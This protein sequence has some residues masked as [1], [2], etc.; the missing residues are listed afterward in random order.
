MGVNE[1]GVAGTNSL[2]GPRART[3]A[4]LL[5]PEQPALSPRALKGGFS[6]DSRT[7]CVSQPSRTNPAGLSV[8]EVSGEQNGKCFSETLLGVHGPVCLARI[9]DSSLRTRV[10]TFSLRG[11][12]SQG[13]Q[14]HREASFP[15]DL[16]WSSAT[17]FPT[18]LP[19][20]SGLCFSLVLLLQF[21]RPRL[22]ASR[23]PFSPDL[24]SLQ[25]VSLLLEA[26]LFAPSE[27]ATVY[28]FPSQPH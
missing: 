15:R 6:S 9:P 13:V 26:W 2:P 5:L 1:S 10:A 24:F 16:A 25:S 18:F 14:D 20:F 19:S 8:G 21:P 3:P 17:C 11:G 23:S 22:S 4:L 7:S 27:F 12:T 28:T